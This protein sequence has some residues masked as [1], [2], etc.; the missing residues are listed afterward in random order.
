MRSRLSSVRLLLEVKE[1]RLRFIYHH[2]DLNIKDF[3]I[4]GV[5]KAELSEV[6][7]QHLLLILERY[8]RDREKFAS[9]LDR[10]KVK[11]ESRLQKLL[12]SLTILQ[13]LKKYLGMAVKILV[14]RFFEIKI[15]N[16]ILEFDRRDQN[17]LVQKEK[18]EA[19]LYNAY[20]NKPERNIWIKMDA[21]DVSIRIFHGA[22]DPY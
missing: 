3:S 9:L 19:E 14:A 20:F 17:D 8:F 18:G 13:I 5:T 12:K 11:V 6:M 22:V 2:L 7:Y 16:L 21:E 4:L 10:K 15:D 1:V